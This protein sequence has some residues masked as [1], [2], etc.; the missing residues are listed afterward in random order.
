[1][2]NCLGNLRNC[3]SGAMVLRTNGN[4]HNVCLVGSVVNLYK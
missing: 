4:E 3:S 1:M 2:E